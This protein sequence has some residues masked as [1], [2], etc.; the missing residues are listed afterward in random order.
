MYLASL[1]SLA[2]SLTLLCS[3]GRTTGLL[4]VTTTRGAPFGA[5]SPS[6]TKGLGDYILAGI[7]AG[8][9]NATAAKLA[10]TS[11]ASDESNTGTSSEIPPSSATPTTTSYSNASNSALPTVTSGVKL[12]SSTQQYLN[13]SIAS[14]GSGL[15]YAN[16][17]NALLLAWS[18]SSYAGR[19]TFTVQTLHTY[20]IGDT[21]TITSITSGPVTTTLCDGVPRVFGGSTGF[22]PVYTTT[23]TPAYLTESSI[24]ITINTFTVTAGPPPDCTV[25]AQDCKVLY[26]DYLASQS[27]D[28]SKDATI[29]TVASKVYANLPACN[30][31]SIIDTCDSCCKSCTIS[32][33]N[34]QMYYWPPTAVGSEC[35]ANRT[36]ITGT[37]TIPGQA[38]TEVIGNRT[39]TSPTV[40]LAFTQVAAPYGEAGYC[41]NPI[42]TAIIPLAPGDVSSVR[43]KEIA[44]CTTCHEG[45]V[46]YTVDKIYSVDYADFVG[47]VPAAAY[48]GQVGCIYGDSDCKTITEEA[49]SPFLSVPTQLREMNSIWSECQLFVDGIWDPPIALQSVQQ[50]AGVS[51]LTTSS[52]RTTV[53]TAAPVHTVG[54]P[55]ASSTSAVVSSQQ[56][57]IAVPVASSDTRLDSGPSEGPRSQ[58]STKTVPSGSAGKD[59]SQPLS[60]SVADPITSASGFST[61]APGNSETQAAAPPPVESVITLASS[62]EGASGGEPSATNP[63]LAHGTTMTRPSN[64]GTSPQN[65]LSIL[66]EA[67]TAANERGSSTSATLVVV[68]VTTG[69]RT[70]TSFITNSETLADPAVPAQSEGAGSSQAG[71]PG[72]KAEGAV[73]GGTT[74]MFPTEESSATSITLATFPPRSTGLVTAG[75]NTFSV[76]HVG[77][78]VILENSATTLTVANGG[79][80]VF[81]GQEVSIATD[82]S[83]AVLKATPTTIGG[84]P[85]EA[86]VT[87]DSHL[88]TAIQSQTGIVIAAAS[89]TFTLSAG[90]NIVYD[91]QTLSLASPTMNDAPAA[92]IN[93]VNTVTLTPPHASILVATAAG[94]TITA[95]LTNNAVILEDASSTL[96]VSDGATPTAP[97]DGLVVSVASGEGGVVLLERTSSTTATG[98]Q[99]PSSL[100]TEGAIA[101][102]TT[103]ASS[104]AT[105]TSSAVA[106][107]ASSSAVER[108]QWVWLWLPML[109]LLMGCQ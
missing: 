54:S 59:S 97:F 102:T 14:T 80:A 78:S 84:A 96:T 35:A 21:F 2:L 90:E 45:P 85:P 109:A 87:L 100:S 46:T 101:S 10:T 49:Y 66:S 62:G 105:A 13:Y 88:F 69:G 98:G 22:G 48:R 99:V 89:S 16:S 8:S 106:T 74:I 37:P 51:W 65:A 40:Y 63:V 56:S 6:A 38:N 95:I 79:S 27:V 93:G 81:E 92:I 9:S 86:V 82:G 55:L 73:V 91:G 53:P 15:A 107:A 36:Y 57:T 58:S 61:N 11:T 77:N 28:I 103:A 104:A 67:E 70:S 3:L 43:F 33:N 50:E 42:P 64:P 83:G 20:T 32:A 75:G 1:G 31:V 39:F 41:G 30:Y 108:R 19:H 5:I 24:G 25:N 17:C 12:S 7:N 47:P 18:S 23:D 52:G 94:H 44:N 76:A 26:D 34:V 4:N 71:H 72:A 68:V 60:S 29:T